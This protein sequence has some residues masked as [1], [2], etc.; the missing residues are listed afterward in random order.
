[1]GFS[2]IWYVLKRDK[3][4][5]LSRLSTLIVIYHIV[6]ITLLILNT[7]CML[8]IYI[9]YCYLIEISNN[10]FVNILFLF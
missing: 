8:E 2:V 7:R 1:M 9:S 5:Q 4:L 10:I 3:D 6:N